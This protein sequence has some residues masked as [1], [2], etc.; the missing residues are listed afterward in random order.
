MSINPK[1]DFGK[2]NDAM[3][4]KDIL[5]FHMNQKINLCQEI[6]GI[7]LADKDVIPKEQ[8]LKYQRCIE[9][10]VRLDYNFTMRRND[11][12]NEMS[13]AIYQKWHGR[14]FISQEN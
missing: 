14:G 4:E 3:K 13:E 6:S 9:Q 2:V 12:E 10:T 8:L 1:F 5:N 7:N 11:I